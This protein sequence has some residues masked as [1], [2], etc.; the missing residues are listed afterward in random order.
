MH[1][2]NR[3]ARSSWQADADPI[4]HHGPRA[5]RVIWKADE[6][7]RDPRREHQR[8]P[9][10]GVTMRAHSHTRTSALPPPACAR[11]TGSRRRS[12]GRGGLV[13]RRCASAVNFSPMPNLNDR[14]HQQ[15]I[16]NLIDDAII[17]NANA[18]RLG[19]GQLHATRW[20]WILSQC[21][22]SLVDSCQ[23]WTGKIAERLSGGGLHINPVG[24]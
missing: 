21:Q 16:N 14:H 18:P 17:S 23:N 3:R 4:T 2:E 9:A 24:H 7:R 22:N 15:T 1:G 5:H 8:P 10:R 13:A 6:H 20:A 19:V 12:S 11:R